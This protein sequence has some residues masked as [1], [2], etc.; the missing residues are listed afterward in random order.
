MTSSCFK[1]KSNLQVKR[2]GMLKVAFAMTTLNVISL[3]HFASLL[4]VYTNIG[5]TLHSKVVFGLSYFVQGIVVL[6]LALSLFS[7]IHFQSTAPSELNYI[8]NYIP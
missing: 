2:A 3:S 5:C 4:S 7:H 6:R 8:I 1:F